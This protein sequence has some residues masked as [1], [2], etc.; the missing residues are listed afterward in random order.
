MKNI[1]LFGLKNVGK[2]TLGKKLSDLIDYNFVDTDNHIEKR[3]LKEF[4]K[5]HTC[6]DIYSIK[7]E[8]FFREIEK[9]MVCSLAPNSKSVIALGGGTAAQLFL[10][11]ILKK[12]GNLIYLKVNYETFLKRNANEFSS[13][14]FAKNTVSPKTFFE[15]RVAIFERLN[16]KV[17]NLENLKEDEIL[18]EMLN[19]IK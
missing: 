14:L 13:S 19:V 15:E 17:I 5:P 2:T 12:L 10:H 11:P 18:K 6:K 8:A 7:G 3:Y 9:E 1:I 16:A 4:K